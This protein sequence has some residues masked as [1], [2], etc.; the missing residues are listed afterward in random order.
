M[1]ELLL[2]QVKLNLA[3]LAGG[4]NEEQLRQFE[5]Q[6]AQLQTENQ[7]LQNQLRHLQGEREKARLAN[8]LPGRIGSSLADA[9]NPV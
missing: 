5:E 1:K 9:G 6:T 4:S 3:S 2:R 8:E 7:E